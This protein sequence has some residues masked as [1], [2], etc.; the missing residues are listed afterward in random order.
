[1]MMW[2]DRFHWPSSADR[3]LFPS[4][5]GWPAKTVGYIG[6]TPLPVLIIGCKIDCW[7]TAL[8]RGCETRLTRLRIALCEEK[9]KQDGF[10]CKR[11]WQPLDCGG[12]S[13]RARTFKVSGNRNDGD[14]FYKFCLPARG[15]FVSTRIFCANTSLC[16]PRCPYQLLHSCFGKCPPMKARLGTHVLIKTTAHCRTYPPL[17]TQSTPRQLRWRP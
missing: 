2:L 14:R 5:R 6:M 16:S 4:Q 3:G 10:I 11:Q 15:Q 9:N 8:I 17:T 13:K 7:S 1:M 12:A